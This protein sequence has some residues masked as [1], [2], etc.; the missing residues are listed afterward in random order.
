M[1]KFA[2]WFVMIVLAVLVGGCGDGMDTTGATEG[3]SACDKQSRVATQ[4][5]AAADEKAPPAKQQVSGPTPSVGEKRPLTENVF[6]NSIGMKLVLIPAGEFLMGSP[7]GEKRRSPYE[8][9]HHVRIRRPFHLGVHEVTQGQWARVMG[10]QPHDIKDEDSKLYGE[11]MGFPMYYVSWFDAVAFCNRLS[12]L[13]GKTPCY[14]I[15]SIQRE[16]YGEKPGI[17]YAEVSIVGGDGYRLPTEAQWEFSCRAGTTTPFHFGRVLDGTQ[18]NC[19]GGYPYGTEIKG[20]N[21]GRTA[22]VGSYD[23]NAWGLHDMHG[24]VQEW[25]EDWF[26]DDHRAHSQKENPDGFLGFRVT[27]GGDFFGFASD[28]RSAWRADLWPGGRF[29]NLGFRVALA[30]T[31]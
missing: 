30:A 19:D 11:G 1:R 9:Q 24:N 4:K 2:V 21:F 15:A 23:A 14:R 16:E 31:E 12:E 25:C 20:P 6:T 8:K 13:E 18:A 27:R 26:D 7:E 5:L 29:P 17:M 22:P 28:C 10:S 3:V